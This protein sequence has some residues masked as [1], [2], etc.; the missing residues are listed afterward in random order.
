MALWCAAVLALVSP[1]WVRPAAA[2]FNHGD[3]YTYHVPLRS[4]TASSLQS[5]RLP[6]WNPYILLGVPHIANAQA[7]LFYPPALVSS[8]FPIVTALV[9][10]Q[11]FH[12][13][14]AG[15]GLFLLARYARLDRVGSAV[16]ASAFALSPFL[17]Y[18]VTAGIP[19]LLAALSWA[20]WLWLAWL[21]GFPGLL[22]AGFALQLLSGH[23]QF[24]VV[25]G[26]AMA[27]WSSCRDG[28]REL[29]TRLIVAGGAA[30]ALTA[31]Q[32]IPTAEFLRHSVRADWGG[33]LSGAY[34]LPPG[35]LWTW[36]NPDALGTP[37]NGGWP[38]VISVF[39][40]T[41]G[42][43]AGPLAL[44]LAAWGLTRGKRR[45]PAL[46]LTVIGTFLAFGP[47]GPL[48]RA[49]LSFAVL[50]YLRTPSRWL[51]L[52]LW[53]VVLLAGAGLA[54]HRGR[55]WAPG[56]RLALVLAG[57]L[58]LAWW[59]AAFLRPQD[60][61]RYLD[62][63]AEIAEKLGGRAERVLTDPELAN[64]NK[65]AL[66]HLM[67][68]NGYEAFYPMGVP[69][70]AA[71]AEGEP[72]ADASRVFVSRWR[73]DAASRAGVAALLSG[74]GVERT[75]EAWPLAS[76]VDAR[77]RR[78]RPDPRLWIERPER[79]RVTGP[80]PEGA[81]GVALSEPAYPGWRARVDGM[82]VG[83]VPWDGIFQALPLP[84]SFP[85][86]ANLD[87]TLEF[88]PTGWAWLVALSACAWAYWLS[89]LARRAEMS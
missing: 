8:F 44:A 56:A 31:A 30:L 20:P 23:G 81:A 85:R 22:A 12:I 63:R 55:R 15:I 14:W 57:F 78:L 60:P 80:V 9:W 58:P 1:V 82:R 89:V 2:F 72:A 17:I 26:V 10:D 6:F 70:W 46:A 54:S 84:P 69:G 43:W 5:G 24:L 19:T 68:V 28:R 18:R 75:L 64:P 21:S 37:L 3:L 4:L 11:I 34:S 66:Y 29:F 45:G 40:E 79:W 77:G 48:S 52:S 36:L 13:L 59:D 73:S 88:T 61:A 87:L 42:G 39:Y 62:P 35:A 47:R 38:D 65:A 76:F 33:A 49:L 83:L 74:A 16:L 25:N 67:N 32:W 53:G 41:C 7:A 71:A 51:F 27:L 86:G 50:S